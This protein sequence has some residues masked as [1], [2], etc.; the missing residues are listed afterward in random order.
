MTLL[1]AIRIDSRK[2]ETKIM[3]ATFRASSVGAALMDASAVDAIAQ[4]I[5]DYEA[6]LAAEALAAQPVVSLMDSLVR[7][8]FEHLKQLQD[9]AAANGYPV[10]Y[11]AV[12]WDHDGTRRLHMFNQGYPGTQA[13]PRLHLACTLVG[14]DHG[15]PETNP[16]G[17]DLLTRLASRNRPQGALFPVGASAPNA[18]KLAVTKDILAQCVQAA[19]DLHAA[20]GADPRGMHIGWWIAIDLPRELQVPLSAEAE[21]LFG[22]QRMAYDL[23]I[24]GRQI[25]SHHFPA[26]VSIYE[27]LSAPVQLAAM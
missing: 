19:A 10:S 18:E 6:Q 16:L 17:L 13:N 24:T 22:E 9:E 25:E 26:F 23:I 2:D 8:Q 5:D 21:A 20:T 11:C 12:A 3:A 4:S 7:V 14:K 1:S 15:A 27:A